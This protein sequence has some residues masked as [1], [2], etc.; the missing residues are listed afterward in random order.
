MAGGGGLNDPGGPVSDKERARRARLNRK[1]REAAPDLHRPHQLPVLDSSLGAPAVWDPEALE[2]AKTLLRFH[3][4]LR[5]GRWGDQ[6]MSYAHFELYLRRDRGDLAVLDPVKARTE[7]LLYEETSE[8]LPSSGLTKRY[9][10]AKKIMGLEQTVMDKE[11]LAVTM[12]RELGITPA[13]WARM[14]AEM[15][16]KKGVDFALVLVEAGEDEA[17]AS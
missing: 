5:D 11:R 1:L 9:S 16:R 17:D 10:E 3:E 12:R 6:V 2:I 13:S 7:V 15:E 14:R 8:G 4:H